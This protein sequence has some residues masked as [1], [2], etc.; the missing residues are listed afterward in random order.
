MK[1]T[2]L[3]E[4][5]CARKQIDYEK[6]R[7][8]TEFNKKARKNCFQIDEVRRLMAPRDDKR[9]LYLTTQ[10]YGWQERRNTRDKRKPKSY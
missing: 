6:I 9:S 5:L 1:T 4:D 2:L 8:E 7:L 10:G 3:N